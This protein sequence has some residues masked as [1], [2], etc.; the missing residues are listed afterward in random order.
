[1]G[2]N[3]QITPGRIGSVFFFPRE[4]LAQLQG[5]PKNWAR[6]TAYGTWEPREK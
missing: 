3:D 4:S 2:P 1:M 6:D 5:K